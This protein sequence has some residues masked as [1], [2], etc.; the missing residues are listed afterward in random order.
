MSDSEDDQL[1]AESNVEDDDVDVDESEE[2]E[3]EDAGPRRKKPRGAGFILDEAGKL[4][5]RCFSSLLYCWPF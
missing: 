1:S 2:E 5:N 3:E 4:D